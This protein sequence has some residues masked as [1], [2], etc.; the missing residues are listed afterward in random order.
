MNTCAVCKKTIELH[1]HHKIPQ[2]CGGSDEESNL[3]WLCP[4]HHSMVHDVSRALKK[5]PALAEDIISREYI[6]GS[7]QHN[8][9]L[10]L[11]K[12]A[13]ISFENRGKKETQKIFLEIPYDKYRDIK[14]HAKFSKVSIQRYLLE[15]IQ[16]YG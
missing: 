14:D 4:N 12:I 13:L 11:A 7:Q 2:S 3:I 9:I 8:L 1:Q 16:R 15:V 5:S 6:I 10:E